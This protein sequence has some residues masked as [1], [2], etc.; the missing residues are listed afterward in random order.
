MFYFLDRQNY[1]TFMFDA[2]FLVSPKH[3][4]IRLHFGEWRSILLL[5]LLLIYFLPSGLLRYY[6]TVVC[7]W[8]IN[9]R[10]MT[11]GNVDGSEIQW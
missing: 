3:Y 7:Q 6:L 10:L 1:E 2:D 5:G 9:N 4:K 11:G 8:M